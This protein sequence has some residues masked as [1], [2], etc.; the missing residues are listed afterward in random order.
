MRF[1]T[2][3]AKAAHTASSAIL[4]SQEGERRAHGSDYRIQQK[5]QEASTHDSQRYTEVLASL[6]NTI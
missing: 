3:V 4:V 2:E 1:F 5:N 6:T